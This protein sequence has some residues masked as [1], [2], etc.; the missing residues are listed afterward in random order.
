M[1]ERWHSLAAG[2]LLWAG[3][4]LAAAAGEHMAI[5]TQVQGS[6]RTAQRQLD[7][8]DRVEAGDSVEL[9]SGAVL[10]LFRAAQYTLTGPGR[11]VVGADAVVRQA[12]TG[13]VRVERQHPAL[14]AA[15]ARRGEA[16]T[17]L[18]GAVVRGQAGAGGIER[19]APSRPVF[20]WRARAHRG[21]WQFRLTDDAGQLVFETTLAQAEIT[22]PASVRLLPDQRYRREL[23]WL[24]RDD[25]AQLEVVPCQALGAADDADVAGLLPPADAEPAARVLY[26]LYL[27]SLGVRALAG[28]VAPELNGL[29][30]SQ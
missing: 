4:T 20:S 28:Q 11:F 22:L 19:V 8:L 14:A 24:G 3:I 9:A 27:R 30:L 29:E 13:S 6:V 5:V 26:S 18:A 2:A 7:L 23:R 10:V 1:L 12:G 15:L 25:T 17:V 16:G 21:Q